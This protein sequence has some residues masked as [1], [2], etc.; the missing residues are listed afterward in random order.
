MADFTWGPTEEARLTAIRD[1]LARVSTATACHLLITRGWRN[2]YLRG[3]RPLQE[4]GLGTRLVGRSRR[5][6]PSVMRRS[7]ASSGSGRTDR[8]DHSERSRDASSCLRRG[9]ARGILRRTA[10]D[11]R[12]RVAD[13]YPLSAIGT[14][15]VVI[16]FLFFQKQL[17]HGLTGGA[18]KG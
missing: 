18:V 4:L 17:M 13:P 3:L 5:R 8:V 14:V 16:V 2:A 12:P 1:D 11:H 6:S 9:P 7:A 10:G 15:P